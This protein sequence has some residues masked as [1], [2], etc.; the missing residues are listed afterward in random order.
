[1][2]SSCR[3]VTTSSAGKTWPAPSPAGCAR[4]TG[5]AGLVTAAA[6]HGVVNGFAVYNA[7]ECSDIQ[8]PTKWNQ[9]RFDN[10]ITYFRCPVRNLGQ[11]VVQRALRVMAGEGGQT[12][13]RRRQQRAQRPAYR[14]RTRRGQAA[15]GQHQDA[16]AVPALRPDRPRV[17]LP[18]SRA[19]TTRSPTTWLPASSR[20]PGRRA[21][22]RTPERLRES[23]C[24]LRRTNWPLT[25]ASQFG[26]T[27]TSFWLGTSGCRRR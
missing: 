12:S 7:V 10:W 18:A 20:R 9:W 6:F 27:V 13:E 24:R 21:T 26:T 15:R 23:A 11:R 19:W 22:G 1:M 3:P 5:D 25:V 2:T 8:W 16:E 17:R 4:A 14:C